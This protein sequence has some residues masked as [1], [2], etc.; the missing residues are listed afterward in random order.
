[1]KRETGCYFKVILQPDKNIRY[2]RARPLTWNERINLMTVDE[3][4]VLLV[5]EWIHKD[6]CLFVALDGRRFT[7]RQIAIEHN[8]TL[9]NSP[10]E[11]GEKE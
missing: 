3:K 1:M 5:W 2:E 9:L 6:E 11:G 4:A 8:K 10:C 7:K